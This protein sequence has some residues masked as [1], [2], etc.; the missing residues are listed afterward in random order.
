MRQQSWCR[1][2]RVWDGCA[3]ACGCGGTCYVHKDLDTASLMALDNK[4]TI[5]N[6]R[7]RRPTNTELGYPK[8]VVVPNHEWLKI[9]VPE[10]KESEG[11]PYRCGCGCH[12]TLRS[13]SAN[14]ASYCCTS[15]RKDLKLEACLCLC[16]IRKDVECKG[17]ITC[18]E[19]YCYFG[20]T[21][22]EPLDIEVSEYYPWNM[23]IGARRNGKGRMNEKMHVHM[24]VEGP[25]EGID[26]FHIIL[27]KCDPKDYPR[28]PMAKPGTK[29]P[30]C[31]KCK[32]MV[33][34][35]MMFKPEELKKAAK[36]A[37]LGVGDEVT[38]KVHSWKKARKCKG[39]DEQLV[40]IED[41]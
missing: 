41:A 1:E 3:A 24:T 31:K 35:N 7:V 13:P 6:S 14:C 12:K 23:T 22:D 5:T 26:L 39:A 9:P 29:I 40:T 28:D 34:D 16:H 32:G 19:D 15:R 21:D 37:S 10:V 4:G 17:T 27:H 2:H 25:K 38:V 8:H 36:D 18:C 11:L 33:W 20:E 30:F